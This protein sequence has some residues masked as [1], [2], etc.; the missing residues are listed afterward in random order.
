MR[1][2]G[3]DLA[4]REGT[5]DQ[6]AN[7]TG[8]AALDESGTL[9]D[10]GWTIGLD[11]TAIW[12]EDLASE[13]TLL[14][15]DAPLVVDNASGQ[16][17]CERQVGQC[18]GRWQVSAN[19]TN[20][21]TK[22]L[23]GVRLRAGLEEAGWRYDD[24]AEGPAASGRVMCECYPYT[25]LVGVAELG[26]EDERPRYK[27]QPKDLSVAE[28][29][30]LRAVTCDELIRRMAALRFAD[31]PLDLQSHPVTEQLLVEASPEADHDYK[32]RD[33]LIDAV[34]CAWTAALWWRSGT[35]HSQAL[36]LTPGRR[37]PQPAMIAPCRPEQRI[38]LR[39]ARRR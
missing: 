13:D 27:R 3:V 17:L 29:R 28:W 5:A 24:G 18:Y 14:F 31:P 8:V 39:A 37:G 15:I 11:Q 10:A 1:F 19:S 20:L 12:I 4:W 35:S 9:L 38:E 7:E 6:A 21:G 30:P 26:Y 33:D 32:H 34:L 25:T 23:G 2:L 22:D 36:G 16:R